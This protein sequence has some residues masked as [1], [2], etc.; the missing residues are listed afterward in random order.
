MNVKNECVNVVKSTEL[1]WD[2][3]TLNLYYHIIIIIIIIIL[4]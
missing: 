3:R 4:L 2:I 1:L